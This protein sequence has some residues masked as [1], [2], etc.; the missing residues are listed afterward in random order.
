M[1]AVINQEYS[2]KIAMKVCGIEL[3]GNDA[4]VTS[5]VGDSVDNYSFILTSVKKIKLKDSNNQNDVISFSKEICSFL[6]DNQFD[7]VGIKARGTKGRFAGGSVSFKI[8]GLIQNSGAPVDIVHG[9]TIKAKMKPYIESI[10]F[11][12]VNSYQKDSLLLAIYL[13]F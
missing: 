11:S 13:L 4:I 10:D 7:K 3:K 1:I 5:I 6:V 9:A 2:K 12:K 8:E